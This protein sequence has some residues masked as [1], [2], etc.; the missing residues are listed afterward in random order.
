MSKYPEKK[1]IKEN[2]LRLAMEHKEKCK[3]SNCNIALL[4][5]RIALENQGIKL[6]KREQEI[7]M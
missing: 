3:N 7:T 4:A 2:L 6:T 1:W 5:V